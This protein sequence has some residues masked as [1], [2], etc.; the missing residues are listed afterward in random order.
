VVSSHWEQALELGP[1]E[2][3]PWD[4]REHRQEVSRE[5]PGFLA[6]H[7]KSLSSTTEVNP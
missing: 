6:N 1:E 4:A 2:Q 5:K 7:S 3:H